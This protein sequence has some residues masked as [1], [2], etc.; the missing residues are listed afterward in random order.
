MSSVSYRSEDFIHQRYLRGDGQDVVHPSERKVLKLLWDHPAVARSEVPEFV[1]LSQQSVYR[2]IDQLAERGIVAIGPPKPGIGRGQ[3][4]P[5]LTLKGDYAYTCG[6]SVNTDIIGICLTDF[7][8]R[9]IAE[10]NVVLRGQGMNEALAAVREK[11]ASLQTANNLQDENLFGIGFGIAAFYVGGTR[12]NAPLPLHE[13][14][15]I[16][17]GPV[18]AHFFGKPVWVNNN[19]NTAAIAE[20]M[21]G[22][23]RHIK[24]FAYLSFNYGFGGG[25][26]SNGELLPGGYGN[27]GS[28]SSMYDDEESKHRPALQFLIERLQENG[29]AVSSI[30]AMRKNFDPNWPG[31]SGWVDEI[32]PSYNRLVNAIRAIFD[33]HAIVFGGQIPERLAEMLISRTTIY[34]RNR[35]GVSKPVP[36]LITSEISS[37]ASAIGASIVPFRATFY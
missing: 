11:I 31:V 19:S 4:S 35:Y 29:V 1:D 3:P 17:L 7:S 20:A 13:W 28:F 26:I 8:G 34:E 14:S 9:I 18:L 2:I 27:A 30:E 24:H 32:T 16:E 10:S 21:F 23:G 33:P 6:V 36:K 25:L 12:Y 5:S 15:L 37:D 22:V